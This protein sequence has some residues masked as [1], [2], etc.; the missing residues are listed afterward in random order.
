MYGGGGGGGG[1]DMV[2]C[3]SRGICLWGWGGI[4][5]FCC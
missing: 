4:C 3:I 2:M 5:L 1:G